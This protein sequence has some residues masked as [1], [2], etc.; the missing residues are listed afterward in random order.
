MASRGPTS[1]SKDKV[2][3]STDWEKTIFRDGVED[4]D[5]IWTQY[6]KIASEFD[7]RMLDDWTR[8]VDT[9]LIYVAL[10]ISIL[11]SYIIETTKYFRPDPADITNELLIAIYARLSD[12]SAPIVNPKDFYNLTP[13]QSL[14]AIYANSL[15]YFSLAV[16]MV[17]FVIASITK[18]WLIRYTREVTTP[19]PPYQRAMRRQDA[20]NGLVAWKVEGIIESLPVLVIVGVVMF[21]IFIHSEISQL[22]ANLGYVIGTILLV[23][24]AFIIVTSL[25][26]AFIPTSP[27][28]SS[29]S[30]FIKVVFKVFPDWQLTAR[31]KSPTMFRTF[32]IILASV[33]MAVATAFFV[34]QKQAAVFQCLF[35]VPIAGTFVLMK[36][37]Q[38]KDTMKPRV[39]GLPEWT[40]FS[41]IAVFVTLS[42][43]SY[44]CLYTRPYIAVFSGACVLLAIQGYYGIRLSEFVP[45]TTEANAVAWMLKEASSQDAAW[46]Q[47]AGEIAGSSEI[48]RAVLLENLLPLLSPVIASI[49][50]PEGH[51][52]QELPDDQEIYVACLARLCQF[53]SSKGSFWR[54]EVTLRHPSL[55]IE[56]YKRLVA[57]RD[58][59]H[60]NGRVR[61]AAA[62]A[63]RCSTNATVDLSVA[64]HE[65]DRERAFQAKA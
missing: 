18:L 20:Y 19:G 28:R 51:L 64:Q 31:D 46:F 38:K 3:A 65:G 50:H 33:A 16:S 53:S 7:N 21:G 34:L 30:D 14:Q 37:P 48:M 47:R 45:D 61:E 57:L 5:D 27:F 52:S 13:E 23:T 17:V 58:C 35:F 39:Y 8:I 41:T 2:P 29:F 11:T 9:M 62:V 55:P 15:I 60:C 63:L 6:L 59:S 44:I 1:F 56:L 26:G 22:Q 54:N 36:Q 12:A 10:F 40:L 43:S 4:D 25:C 49:P 42:V 24:L 32:L